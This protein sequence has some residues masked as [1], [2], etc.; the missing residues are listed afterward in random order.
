MCRVLQVSTAGSSDRLHRQPSVTEQRRQ[1]LA[2][3]VRAIHADVKGRYGSSR[4]YA[5]LVSTRQPDLFAFK[6]G[7]P[8]TWPMRLTKAV[9]AIELPGVPTG[10]YTLRCRTLDVRGAAWPMPRPF[11]KSGRCD[12]EW[13]KLTVTA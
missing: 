5:E 9:W 8:T 1:A 7:M 13:V 12:N 6:D 4:M 10:E 11:K 3:V 2:K